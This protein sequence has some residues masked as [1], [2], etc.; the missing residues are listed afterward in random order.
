MK[1][2]G[3][4]TSSTGLTTQVLANC[5]IVILIGGGRGFF[6]CGDA[7]VVCFFRKRYAI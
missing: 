4:I 3:D 1:H 6:T 7:I 5:G 2:P